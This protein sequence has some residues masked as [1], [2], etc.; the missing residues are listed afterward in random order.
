MSEKEHPPG[1]Q[2]SMQNS[3]LH[4]LLKSYLQNP[5]RLLTEIKNLKESQ[6]LEEG[7]NIANLILI[8]LHYHKCEGSI[9]I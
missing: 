8:Y 6:L 5:K 3:L 1:N 7:K 4:K 9:I 2:G